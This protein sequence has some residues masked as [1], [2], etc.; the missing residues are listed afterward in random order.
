M[1]EKR[2]KGQSKNI[3]KREEEEEAE[4]IGIGINIRKCPKIRMKSSK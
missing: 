2:E 3:K 4:G 1:T